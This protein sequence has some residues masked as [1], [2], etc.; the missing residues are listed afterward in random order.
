LGDREL[1]E[2]NRL[3]TILLDIFED[4]LDIGRITLMAEA[5]QLLD[6]QLKGLNRP[7]LSHGGSVSHADA[8]KHAKQQYRKF[9]AKRRALRAEEYARE[10]AELR[11]VDKRL[12]KTT[13]RTP[14]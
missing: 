9:N 4:Q 14:E 7:V 11:A 10:I 2:L 1:R 5:A 8:E 6:A 12:P 3:T 13:K